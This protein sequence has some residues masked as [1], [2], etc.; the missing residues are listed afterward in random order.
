MEWFIDNVAEKGVYYVFFSVPGRP[1]VGCIR[2]RRREWNPSKVHALKRRAFKGCCTLRR[3][4]T[5][6]FA[7]CGRK[8][9]HRTLHT[10]THTHKHT[11]IRIHYF[12]MYG[13][14]AAAV[15]CRRIAVAVAFDSLQMSIRAPLPPLPPPN[16]NRHSQKLG[17]I[18]YV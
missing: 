3:S 5:Y 10:H 1:S 7:L 14:K 16:R 12:I 11:Y 9:T 2:G 6:P 4:R 15:D 8:H 18:I 13:A 17:F